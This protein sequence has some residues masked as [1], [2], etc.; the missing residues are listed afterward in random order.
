MGCFTAGAMVILLVQKDLGSM[1]L[2]FLTFICTFYVATSNWLLTL[3]GA[4]GG[5]PWGRWPAT[6]LFSHVRVRVAIWQNPW[7]GC[8]GLRLSDGDP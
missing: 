1:L 6:T 2:Y 5:L 4:G 7:G 3:A 8:G